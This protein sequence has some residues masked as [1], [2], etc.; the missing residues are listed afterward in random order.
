MPTAT[1]ATLVNITSTG[2]ESSCIIL[3]SVTPQ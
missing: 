1:G 2:N 3:A